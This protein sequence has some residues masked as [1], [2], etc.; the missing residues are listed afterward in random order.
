MRYKKKKGRKDERKETR[1][2]RGRGRE[3]V[4]GISLT[5]TGGV[6]IKSSWEGGRTRKEK[7]EVFSFGGGM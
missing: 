7:A 6:D 2:N 1:S 3:L 4:L 5:A